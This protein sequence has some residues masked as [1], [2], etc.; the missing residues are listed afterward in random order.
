VDIKA[1][2]SGSRRRKVSK[3][4]ARLI[5]ELVEVFGFSLAET[6]RHLGVTS[7]AVAK[8]LSRRGDR[9]I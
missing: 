2:K 5:E 1:L 3:L 8:V 9:N 6:G 7:S 4:R